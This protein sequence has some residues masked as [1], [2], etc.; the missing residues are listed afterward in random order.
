MNFW[1][2]FVS[3]V[4]NNTF[5]IY[6][7]LENF[8]I[9]HTNQ[10]TVI[11]IQYIIKFYKRVREKGKRKLF[12]LL[13]KLLIIQARNTHSNLIKSY[14]PFTSNIMRLKHKQLIYM[15]R[16][17]SKSIPCFYKHIIYKHIHRMYWKNTRIK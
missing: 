2:F 1:L 10:R 3:S 17:F 12:I 8:N 16:M 15:K 13:K 5:L 11:L 9:D 4:F 14:F 7:W 6:I